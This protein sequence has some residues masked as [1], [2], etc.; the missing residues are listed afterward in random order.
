MKFSFRVF[1]PEKRAFELVP[2]K[3]PCILR[4][5]LHAFF[6]CYNHIETSPEMTIFAASTL[7][8][9]Y[10]MLD[11]LDSVHATRTKNDTTVTSVFDNACS[12]MGTVFLVGRN[13]IVFQWRNFSFPCAF[14]AL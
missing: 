9:V 1:V 7:I 14:P 5:L 12:N 8:F 4:C 6:L 13:I 3:Y 2:T 11:A 10:W